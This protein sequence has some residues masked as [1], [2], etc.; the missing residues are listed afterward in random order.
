MNLKEKI[1]KEFDKFSKE[2]PRIQ[3]DVMLIVVN[4]NDI[5][6]FIHEK[7]REACLAVVPELEKV[8]PL[9]DG[10]LDDPFDHYKTGWNACRDKTLENINKV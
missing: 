10:T 3:K 7:I 6:Q 1:D 5:K 2:D 9:A 4:P 8:T